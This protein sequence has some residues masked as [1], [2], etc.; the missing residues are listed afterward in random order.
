[1][2]WLWY[3]PVARELQFDP[4]PGNPHM[5]QGVALKRPKKKDTNELTFRTETD[6]QA[7]KTNLWVIKGDR[8]G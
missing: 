1:M 8:W 2:L 6:S 5:L 7:L 3:R 4:Q